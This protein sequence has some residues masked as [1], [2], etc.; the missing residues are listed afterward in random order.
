MTLLGYN[1]DV[2]DFHGLSGRCEPVAWWEKDGGEFHHDGAFSSKSR[3]VPALVVMYCE[4]A[5][6][7][8]EGGMEG[9]TMRC[10]QDGESF[11]CPPGSTLFF[12]TGRAL[13]LADP[14][15]ARRARRMTCVYT[16]GFDRVKVGEYPIMCVAAASP[17]PRCCSSRPLRSL[18]RSPAGALARARR[19]P[20][21]LTAMHPPSHLDDKEGGPAEGAPEGGESGE[22]EKKC[23]RHALVQ[24]DPTSGAES[25]LVTWTCLSYL[26]EEDGEGN[27][28]R[29]EYEEGRLFIEELLGPASRPE[30][31][32]A[33]D[34]SSGDYCI[35]GTGAPP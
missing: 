32:T 25:V 4:E 24:R 16:G 27:A 30:Y 21:W 11:Y 1:L 33:V 22:G 19:S 17:P 2:Q 5:P 20:T 8:G 3:Q 14:E 18:T 31:L 26:E 9:T 12:K 29:L 6:G 10:W 7:R 23:M 15:L 28:R 35:F 13:E 34:Y